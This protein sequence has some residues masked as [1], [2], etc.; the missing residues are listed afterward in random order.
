VNV[1]PS[2]LERREITSLI[3]ALVAPRP[4]A[5]VSSIAPDGTRNLAPFS[6]FNAFS[7]APPTVAIGPG[8]RRGVPKDSQANIVASGEFVINMVSRELAET[9]NLTSGEFEGGVDEWELAGVTPLPSI[10]VAPARVAESPA[11]LECRVHTV[12]DLGPPELKTNALIIA[13]V[14]RIH[15]ADELL[16]GYVPDPDGLDLV[17]RMG[18]DL[19]SGTRERFELP[20][21]GSADPAAVAA[22]PPRVR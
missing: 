19:W 4:I 17:G 18:G 20:R 12:V 5:W 22:E 21:P 2:T 13:R 11:S 1:D 7:T 9:A 15:V 14:V 3:N 6:F 16:D 8:S 10:D